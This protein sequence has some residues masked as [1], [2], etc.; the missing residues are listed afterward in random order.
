MDHGKLGEAPGSRGVDASADPE[1]IR[2]QS[3]RSQILAEKDDAA[4]AFGV[5]VEIRGHAK[6]LYDCL[7]PC[8]VD[9][10]G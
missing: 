8:F 2:A 10:S 3:L 9:G 5:D 4:L 6:F 7:L 1:H